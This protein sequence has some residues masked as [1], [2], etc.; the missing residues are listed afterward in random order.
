MYYLEKWQKPSKIKGLRPLE[1][2]VC[3]YKVVPSEDTGMISIDEIGDKIVGKI[4]ACIEE[5]YFKDRDA[6]LTFYMRFVSILRIFIV[7]RQT[8]IRNIRS[9][10]SESGEAAIDRA[11]QCWY[12]SKL[13]IKMCL[14]PWR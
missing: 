10:F 14:D 7:E 11:W 6:F 1:I 8:A 9:K 13:S 5:G 2:A 3:S 12:S 4:V